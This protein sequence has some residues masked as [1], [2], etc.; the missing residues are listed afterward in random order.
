MPYPSSHSAPAPHPGGFV[1][2]CSR[3][4]GTYQVISIDEET[5]SCWVRRWPLTRHGSPAFS[6][7]L[8]DLRP[9]QTTGR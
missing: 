3:Q 2:L 5:H 1:Q 6:V 8:P 7:A 9:L 4:G